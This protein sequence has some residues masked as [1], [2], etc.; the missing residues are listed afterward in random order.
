MLGRGFPAP[1]RGLL[2]TDAQTWCPRNRDI[3][4]QAL[5]WLLFPS[6]AQ[7]DFSLWLLEGR[8]L[9]S[10]SSGGSCNF[11]S[12][13]CVLCPFPSH[14]AWFN[15]HN[16]LL[17]RPLRL[18]G[19]GSPGVP[20]NSAQA[21]LLLS[22]WPGH[23]SP[24]LLLLPG[25]DPRLPVWGASRAASESLRAV[26]EAGP[27]LSA[28]LCVGGWAAPGPRRLY[29]QQAPV[30]LTV[31]S[32]V[33]LSQLSCGQGPPRWQLLVGATGPAVVN[34]LAHSTPLWG[35]RDPGSQPSLLRYENCLLQLHF[36]RCICTQTQSCW[37]VC[38]GR[39]ITP[40]FFFGSAFW[41]LTTGPSLL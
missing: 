35:W 8:Q 37:Q 28:G 34:H 39:V 11:G 41:W 15:A 10:Q 26:A 27:A 30:S 31:A 3:S 7:S 24:A 20:S 36:Q 4:Q 21:F 33:Y 19:L 6:S 12:N 1:W 38:Q 9:R 18:A 16:L 14:S 2:C 23:W 40:S 22:P 25:P 29:A 17:G 32:A 5:A 13:C